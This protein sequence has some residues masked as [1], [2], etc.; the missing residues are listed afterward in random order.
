MRYG[1]I[2]L[3]IEHLLYFLA[4]GSRYV[5]TH[6]LKYKGMALMFAATL[7]NSI[8]A[9]ELDPTLEQ[10]VPIVLTPTRLRQSLPDA[11]ASVTLITSE[12]IQNY[13]LRSIPDVL[14]LVPGMAVTQITGNDY[15]IN[16]HGGNILV[17]RRMN[18]LLDGMS[19]Y[20]SRVS[21]V[22]WKQLPVP[23]ED[24]ERIEVTRGSNSA[25]YG[26][27]SLLA[28]VNIIT[29][30][31]H[32]AFGTTI[33]ATTGSLGT[34]RKIVRHGGNSGAATAYRISVEQEADDGFDYA[35]SKGF[36]HDS[37]E[38]T[39]FNFRSL[40]DIA[41]LETLDFRA[42][43]SHGK[44]EVEYVDSTQQFFPDID[45]RDYSLSLAWRKNTSINHEV[46]VKS[47]VTGSRNKQ[48]WRSCVPAIYLLP[49]VT[50]LGRSNPDYVKLVLAG[51]PPSGGT[52][53]DDALAV[54]AI[55]AIASLGSAGRS[56]ICGDTNQ[57]FGE[58]RYDV[59][60][61]DTA[62]LNETFRMVNGVGARYNEVDSET[63]FGGRAS[64]KIWR[65]FSNIEYKPF[66]QLT[67][68]AGGFFEKDT[69]TGSAFSPRVALNGHLNENN[70]FRFV[71]AKANRMPD[72]LEQ[73]ANWNYHG[74]NYSAP[75][76]GSLDGHFA[77]S[78]I[79]PGNLSSEKILSREIGY[80]GNF[81]KNGVMLDAKVFDDRFSD[82]ISEKLQNSD[83]RP[84][85]GNSARYKGAELQITCTPTESISLLFGYSN[86]QTSASNIFER[87]QYAK[88][89]GVFGASYV[90]KSKWNYSLAAY[91]YG[92]NT[93]G[94]TY[95]GREDLTIFKHYR[96]GSMTVT[97]LLTITHLDNKS[98]R[99]LVDVG[100]VRESRYDESM[101]YYAS[102]ALSF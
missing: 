73:R 6:A 4:Q 8:I 19:V 17:P 32:E 39:R 96:V 61:Q 36:G 16:Y 15:R 101:Q 11:P 34:N 79:A 92:G 48:E 64:S 25:S 12:M 77:F 26:S 83:F 40:T 44:V 89:S 98:S 30:H 2:M 52:P 99:F 56:T 63:Y 14:R 71:V 53:E 18:V 41:T 21:R 54:S 94:Q 81:P 38:F 69:M 78:A 86:L 5:M 90:D 22:D 20:G 70:T 100:R 45:V 67:I 88:H 49:E 51:R 47:Y 74:S 59:E 1:L 93:N 95:Y 33:G 35:S 3:A 9:N 31:P 97:P 42:T 58:H 80:F 85:N 50:A 57:N 72:L 66:K 43:L 28:I 102:L 65:L 29:K 87:T 76:N 75:V 37:R 24:I 10:N 68:N 13:G 60:F 84:T 62:V 55:A 23:I 27:N 91:Q 82:L 46:Q 7:H